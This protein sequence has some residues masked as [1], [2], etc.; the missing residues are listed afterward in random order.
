MKIHF[1]FV[2]LLLFGVP[3]IAAPEENRKITFETPRKPRIITVQTN[4][5]VVGEREFELRTIQQ[6]A[7]LNAE[8]D[9]EAS[10]NKPMWLFLGCVP[11]IGLLSALV[12]NPPVPISRFIGNSSEYIVVYTE[13]YKR[14]MKALQFGFAFAGCIT[15]GLVGGGALLTIY[16]SGVTD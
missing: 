12:Y 13:A 5:V 15:G 1:I 9:A 6:R 4:G 14:K 10:I 16:S 2:F 3:L 11:G 8:N 7:T